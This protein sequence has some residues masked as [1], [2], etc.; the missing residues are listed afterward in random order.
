MEESERLV[1]WVKGAKPGPMF[2]CVG[3]LHGNEAAGVGGM[4]DVVEQL[5]PRAPRMRGDFVALRGNVR[6]LRI[7]RRFLRYDLNRAWAP[8][9]PAESLPAGGTVTDEDAEVRELLAVLEEVRRAARGQLYLLDLHTTSGSGGAFT[10]VGDSLDNRAFASAIPVP[11]VLGLEELVEGTLVGCLS[12][13]GWTTAVFECG[14]H[15]E[16]EAR[17]RAEAAIWILIREAGLLAPADVTE[18]DQAWEA[19][20]GEYRT[21]PRVLE[22]RYRHPVIRGDE[23]RTRPGLLNF[24]TVNE[25]EVLGED[26]G[27]RITAPETGRILMPLY[28]EQGEDGFF[29]VRDFSR[30]W[31]TISKALRRLGVA[32]IVHWLPGVSRDPALPGAL[33]A[34]RRVARWF[35]LELFHLLGYR[36]HLEDKHRLVVVQR[37]RRFG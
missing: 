29:L 31:L 24:Q 12:E 11:L 34:N 4:E 21:L 9:G 6:A 16:P 5:Q 2:L 36:R 10:T 20:A 3:G 27:G 37:R 19:L 1:G 25:G 14:Q 33:V 13:E 8:A 35:A 30:I 28:Q 32:R 17:R 7:G 18:A 22:M 15:Y 23:Y 26:R